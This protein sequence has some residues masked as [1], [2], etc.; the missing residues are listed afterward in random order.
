MC[1]TLISPEVPTLDSGL[2]TDG[3]GQTEGTGHEVREDLV[4]AWGLL[5]LVFAEI[6]DLQGGRVLLGAAEGA[7]ESGLGGI[8]DSP[9]LLAGGNGGARRGQLLPGASAQD[10]AGSGGERHGETSNCNQLQ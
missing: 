1:A 10:R 7:I 2:S 4:G 9:P 8:S 6:G 5:G 3:R